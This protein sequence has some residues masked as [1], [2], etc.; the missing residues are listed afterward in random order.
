MNCLKITF[1]L[2]LISSLVSAISTISAEPSRI[3]LVPASSFIK[4]KGIMKVDVY[5]VNETAASIR[6]PSEKSYTI[7][8]KL[9][10]PTGKRLPRSGSNSQFS[11]SN[12]PITVPPRGITKERIN[13]SLDAE[14]GD[15]V[16]LFIEFGTYKPQRSNSVLLFCGK[17]PR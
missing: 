1:R 14:Q 7:S 2:C 3:L 12:I 5:F 6:F 11:T 10:D 15:L 8:Y 13:I 17:G 4:P 16:S 9:Q